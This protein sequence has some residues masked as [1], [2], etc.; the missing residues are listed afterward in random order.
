MSAAGGGWRLRH[1]KLLQ[2]LLLLLLG[3][4][5]ALNSNIMD[6]LD[7]QL[8][9]QHLKVQEMHSRGCQEDSSI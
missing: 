4:A 7:V 8:F 2:P 9:Q 3:C 1:P 5:A 6:V